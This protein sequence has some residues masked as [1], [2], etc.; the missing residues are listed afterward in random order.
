MDELI[1]QVSEKLHVPADQ[2]K[3]AVDTVLSYLKTKLP[4]PIAGQIDAALAGGSVADLAKGIG[5]LFGHK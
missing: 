3:T 4:P 2:A 5:G 1:K